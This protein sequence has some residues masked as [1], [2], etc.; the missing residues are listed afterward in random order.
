[1]RIG[2]STCRSEYDIR[3]STPAG[4]TCGGQACSA[5]AEINLDAQPN[6][7]VNL[8]IWN[9]LNEDQLISAG[10]ALSGFSFTLSNAPGIRQRGCVGSTGQYWSGRHCNVPERDTTA[11]VGGRPSAS[12]RH[13]DFH[14]FG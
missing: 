5:T 13:W 3:F 8:G 7:V 2:S 14:R 9:T 1:M 6:G 10:Q 11:V 12:G 4:S